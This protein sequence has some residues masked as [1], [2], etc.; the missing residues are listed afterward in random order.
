MSKNEKVLGGQ[1]KDGRFFINPPQTEPDKNGR[2]AL[3][4]KCSL[5]PVE[6]W[7]W[8]IAAGGVCYIEYKW[9][10]NEMYESDSFYEEIP[11]E[12]L[13]DK[14]NE[15]ADYASDT[16]L[17]FWKDIYES[18]VKRF[19]PNAVFPWKTGRIK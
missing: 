17:A 10:E 13:L 16:P 18:V 15:I 2:I 8:G 3:A 4:D 1:L 14:L 5:G 6:Y 11:L 9:L 19:Y 12:K 7:E